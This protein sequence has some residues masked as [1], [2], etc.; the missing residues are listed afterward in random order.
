MVTNL[1][2]CSSLSVK[3]YG[4][5]TEYNYSFVHE[6]DS[7]DGDTISLE[8]CA[9]QIVNLPRC[10]IKH[11]SGLLRHGSRYPSKNSVINMLEFWKQIEL[12]LK[13][14]DSVSLK[15]NFT[16]AHDSTLAEN[17]KNEHYGIGRRV[18]KLFADL[19]KTAS[20]DE[21]DFL[22]TRK[23][24][25]TDSGRAF[26]RGVDDY[27]KTSFSVDDVEVR[28]DLLRYYDA[29]RQFSTRLKSEVAKA[30]LVNF[31]KHPDFVSLAAKLQNALSLST[32]LVIDAGRYIF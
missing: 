8:R 3:W 22:S 26:Q 30:E 9:A 27:L 5:K 12:G 20:L 28:D 2:Q 6:C 21:V 24:R 18:A 17:G 32:P 11:V 25:T 13:D 16:E 29:C 14:K 10:R 1:K 19:L 7:V 4:T 31:K 23:S 15:T